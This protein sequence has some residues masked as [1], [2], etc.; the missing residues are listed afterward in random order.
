MARVRIKDIADVVGLSSAAVSFALNGKPGVSDRVREEVLRVATELGWRP[1]AAARSLVEARAGALGLVVARPTDSFRG[2]TFYLQLIAGISRALTRNETSLVLDIVDSLDDEIATYER[3]YSEHRVDGVFVVDPRVH[4]PR[5]EILLSFDM[6]AVLIGGSG[7]T[8]L[9]GV[10]VSDELAM[11]AVVDHLADGG[12]RHLAYVCGIPDL[13]HSQRRAATFGEQAARRGL[14]TEPVRFT[15]YSAAA[16]T[17]ATEALLSL[18]RRPDAVVFDNDG[19][20]LA[21]LSVLHREGVRIPDD[22]AVV[23]WED[24]AMWTVLRPSIT[25]LGRDAT[26]LGAD[27]AGLLLELLSGGA[28]TGLD[29]SPPRVIVRESSRRAAG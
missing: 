27:A 16:G 28:R 17:R 6:P 8:G 10:T 24:N 15:D 11:G 14:R 29:E 19:L 26:A 22:L 20:A 21:G 5:P 18:E 25:A 13:T 4:D 2:D 12:Y 1:N 23:A 7:D 3:W 9:P